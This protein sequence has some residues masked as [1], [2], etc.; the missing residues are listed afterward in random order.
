MKTQEMFFDDGASPPKDVIA[1]W[2]AVVADTFDSSPPPEGDAPCIAVHCIA[3]LG[4]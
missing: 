3:G 2:H 1:R 4:R